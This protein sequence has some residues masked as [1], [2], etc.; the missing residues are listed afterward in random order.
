MDVGVHREAI[1]ARRGIEVWAP[2]HPVGGR[3]SGVH[4][5]GVGSEGGAVKLTHEVLGSGA[6]CAGGTPRVESESDDPFRGLA[7][8]KGQ[9]EK[10]RAFPDAALCVVRTEFTRQR[11]VLEVV[12]SV[13]RKLV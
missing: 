11:P 5:I 8:I 4:R 13:N 7:A 1:V 6:D 9:L 12:G 2:V 10:T 3:V